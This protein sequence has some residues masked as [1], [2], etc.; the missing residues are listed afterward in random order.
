MRR[1]RNGTFVAKRPAGRERRLTGMIEDF[2]E[3]K[4][5]TA[6]TVLE[7]KADVA[8]GEPG[9]DD[10]IGSHSDDFHIGRLRHFERAVLLRG[11]VL[12]LDIG[13]KV[14]KLDLRNAAI[15]HVLRD[16]L[17]LKIWE[18]HQQVEAVAADPTW[19]AC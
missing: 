18:D 2:S 11:G 10:G 16:R 5:D 4:F 14:A 17:K 9:R 8:T 1:R 15:I 6:A 3:L 13:R 7:A 12:P 19:R